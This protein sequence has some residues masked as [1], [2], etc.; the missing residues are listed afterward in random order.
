MQGYFGT[1]ISI[2]QQHSFKAEYAHDCCLKTILKYIWLSNLVSFRTAIEISRQ[3][4]LDVVAVPY[5]DWGAEI[6]GP[7]EKALISV[8]FVY[9]H[10]KILKY[11]TRDSGGMCDP[12]VLSMQNARN[13]HRNLFPKLESNLLI[14]SISHRQLNRLSANLGFQSRQSRHKLC[15]PSEI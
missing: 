13:F 3:A 12:I 15:W 7:C 2:P 9:T 8:L 14:S 6:Y 5:M 1:A 11:Q 10:S 4:A